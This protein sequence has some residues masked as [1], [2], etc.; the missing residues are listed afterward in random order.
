MLQNNL[1]STHL[2]PTVTSQHTCID[3]DIGYGPAL[4]GAAEVP[5]NGQQEEL[6]FHPPAPPVTLKDGSI[7]QGNEHMVAFDS[8]F[9][10]TKKTENADVRQV[11]YTLS[12]SGRCRTITAAK[13]VCWSQQ[14]N[15]IL[16]FLHRL[17]EQL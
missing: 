15:M 3:Q 14:Y 4:G 1:T 8:N 9:I 6:D 13:I 17:L 2:P 16:T 5:I 7:E 11:S 12:L 10:M